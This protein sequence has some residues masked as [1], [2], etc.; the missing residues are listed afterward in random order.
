M[1]YSWNVS[2]CR[3]EMKKLTALIESKECK[4]D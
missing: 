3:Y 2:N 1:G 4:K